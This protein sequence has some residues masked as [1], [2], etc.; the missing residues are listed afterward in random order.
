MRLEL[1]LKEKLKKQDSSTNNLH[2]KIK[3]KIHKYPNYKI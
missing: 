3:M 2:S 1:K